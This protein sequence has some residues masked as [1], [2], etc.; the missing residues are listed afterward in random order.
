MGWAGVRHPEGPP[1]THQLLPQGGGT[2]P[3]ST[4]PAASR[5]LRQ[6]TQQPRQLSKD[7]AAVGSAQAAWNSSSQTG[8]AGHSPAPHLPCCAHPTPG[9]NDLVFG[10][11]LQGPGQ[12]GR[13]RRERVDV[14]MGLGRGARIAS[15]PLP[16]SDL[17]ELGSAL[18]PPEFS[19]LQRLVA[20]WQ[21]LAE[22]RAAA[23]TLPHPRPAPPCTTI[24]SQL[25]SLLPPCSAQNCHC[26]FDISFSKFFPTLG[27]KSCL[28]SN[29]LVSFLWPS[30][31]PSC[32]MERSSHETL[33]THETVCVL[34][35]SGVRGES[36]FKPTCL[37]LSTQ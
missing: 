37:V 2:R 30:V 35:M 36:S 33:G 7:M 27:S 12:I 21:L 14:G 17:W 3:E 22:H 31:S 20:H 10:N 6:V 16:P 19:A 13:G 18:L 5:F 34:C 8:I 1:H 26:A 24:P 29:D 32:T 25:S 15:E 9:V 11:I 28:C 23:H 4:R